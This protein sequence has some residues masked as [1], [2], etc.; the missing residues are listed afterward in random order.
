MSSIPKFPQVL[1][2]DIFADLAA[3]PTAGVTV[4]TPN[5][6][7]AIALKREFDKTQAARGIVIWGAADILPISAFV[8]RVY[9]DA[10][11]S[12]PTHALPMLLTPA[13]EQILWEDA[14]NHSDTGP[15]LLAVAEAARLAREA[16]QL[17]HAW[18]LVPQLGNFALNEDGKAFQDWSQRYEQATRRALQIDQTRLYDLVTGLCEHGADKPKRVACYGFDIIT[19]Q[20][21]ALLSKLEEAG[22]EVMLTRPQSQLQPRNGGVRRMPCHDS[23]DEIRRAAVWARTRIEADSETRIGIVVPG[24]SRH[25]SMIMRI[26]GSIM[27]PDIQRSLP[28]A[29]KRITPFNASLGMPLS[30][31]PLIGVALMVLELGGR[32]IEFEHASLLLRS[33]F[34]GGGETEMADRARL[35]AQLRKRAEPAITL[36]RLLVLIEREHGGASCP[37]LV[38]ALSAL[39]EF[40]KARLFGSQPPSMLARAISE[41]L[42]IVGFP[43]ERELDSSEYQTLRKWQEVLAEFGGLGRVVPRTGYSEGI[44][45][46]RRM[47]A[48]TLF[49]PETPDVPIQI[50]GVFEAAGMQFDHLW[51]MG[52]SD[53][54][55]PPQ[56]SPNPF[57]P[58]ELQRAAKLPQGSA[59]AS[60]ELAQRLT[61]GWVSSADEIILSHPRH[62]D[63]R[64]A[65]ELMPSPLIAPIAVRELILPVHASHRDLVHGAGRL[66]YIN[67]DKAP[68]LDLPG[69]INGDVSGGTAVIKDHAACPFRSLAVHRFGAESIRTPRAGLDAMERGILVHHVLARTWS[70]LETKSAL[71]AISEDSLEAML[72]HAA[73]EAIASIQRDRPI[74]LSGRFAQIEQR[75]LVRLAREWLNEERKRDDFAVTAIEN[76]RS[77]EIGGLTLSTRLDR[78]DESSDGRRLIIDYKTR[79]P[80]V[81]AMLG[82]RPEE[83]QLP[84]YLL[85]AEPDAV[86]V[87]FAQVKRGDMRFA[88]L[89]RDGDLLPGVK[90]FGESRLGDR[91]GSWEELVD[92]WRT[93]FADIAAS[94]ASGDAQVDPK[95]FPHTCRYCDLRPFCRIDERIECGLPEQEDEE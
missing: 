71:D 45:R 68:A 47:A 76:K 31:Y 49:Q 14:I 82:A 33:P 13:Q 26:F 38:Q 9:E 6:R 83:P 74:T 24:F 88:T 94:F 10:L 1:L 21:A 22:C 32:E 85:A 84:L 54:V 90:A 23:G 55:W 50:L 37:I 4:L 28:G 18:Y 17:A 77:I 64:D 7:L 36:E 61:D 65:R 87:T 52:L 42:R 72:A 29:A 60:L 80:S 8:E 16:W 3:G 20:Q 34:L 44:S 91:Y 40:R 27:E 62:G 53:E 41:A 79:A 89:A 30:S 15:A 78:V 93:D 58:I 19:P 48:E 39:A 73:K 35:D 81:N 43:G 75:R 69:G 51:V 59:V 92:A 70:Q 12:R 5:R 11:Y 67:D 2:T 95:Q 63:D 46:L 86:A 57:L 56:P 25:R 66:E